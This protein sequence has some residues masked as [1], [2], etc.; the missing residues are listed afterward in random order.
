MRTAA[1]MLAWF[2]LALLCASALGLITYI[3]MLGG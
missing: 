2:F 3:A 1:K